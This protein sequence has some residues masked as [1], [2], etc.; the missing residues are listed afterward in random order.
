M[1]ISKTFAVFIFLLLQP[2]I[3]SQQQQQQQQNVIEQQSPSA[4]AAEQT[5]PLS[6]LHNTLNQFLYQLKQTGEK[7]V[8]QTPQI[9]SPLLFNAA[10][11]AAAMGQQQQR[12]SAGD[13]GAATAG[14]GGTPSAVRPFVPLGHVPLFPSS[15]LVPTAAHLPPTFRLPATV[16]EQH[17]AFPMEGSPSNPPVVIVSPMNNNQ[18]Q[19][20]K[21]HKIGSAE[22]TAGDSTTNGTTTDI[23][24]TTI[25]AAPPLSISETP[26]P[27]TVSNGPTTVSELENTVHDD[28]HATVAATDVNA[29]TR[30]QQQ[31]VVAAAVVP[32][33]AVPIEIETTNDTTPNVTVPVPFASPAQ[34][35]P[36]SVETTTVTEPTVVDDY[37][38]QRQRIFFVP[39]GVKSIESNGSRQALTAVDL[40]A[41]LR[42]ANVARILSTWN[43]GS[44]TSSGSTNANNNSNTTMTSSQDTKLFL[45]LV[46][47][48]LEQEVA[49]RLAEQ[50]PNNNNNNNNGDSNHSEYGDNSTQ[51]MSPPQHNH[52]AAVNTAVQQVF[53]TAAEDEARQQ[54]VQAVVQHRQQQSDNNN[55]NND[56]LERDLEERLL[57]SQKLLKTANTRLFSLASNEAEAVALVPAAGVHRDRA[58]PATQQHH[59]QQQLLAATAHQ[60]QKGVINLR[61][62][63]GAP[64]Q[65]GGA[66]GA[67]VEAAVNKQR[68]VGHETDYKQR[69][70]AEFD[71]LLDRLKA[72]ESIADGAELGAKSGGA[73]VAPPD[74]TDL[75][76]IVPPR[77]PYPS[78][79]TSITN[80]W[81]QQQQQH[82]APSPPPLTTTAQHQLALTTPAPVTL[83][84]TAPATNSAIGTAQQQQQQQQ[85]QAGT[86]DA[87]QTSSSS[88]G[89]GGD[90]HAGGMMLNRQHQFWSRHGPKT[91]FERLVEDYRWRLMGQ[92]SQNGLNDLIKALRNSNIGFFDRH[93]SPSALKILR[94]VD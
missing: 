45:A 74:D 88:G 76:L 28:G 30:Q 72:E 29:N 38:S 67:T 85:Q 65:S 80:K 11:A 56:D 16:M 94:R 91:K 3:R 66:A 90:G 86:N 10:A 13:G 68:R 33:L 21:R 27:N 2:S 55:N 52:A 89:G 51:R 36:L 23:V 70:Q 14:G 35:P 59:H 79:P 17:K 69:E 87:G 77:P 22:A 53:S 58:V 92:D 64:G 42:S 31:V 57:D 39:G 26:E 63:G 78:D 8:A 32:P 24:S 60:Q 19:H 43:N 15:L 62:G 9:A 71:R 7:V 20:S 46:E 93:S 50:Q 5:L 48:V 49:R 75:L 83:A 44:S 18:L 73:K 37:G 25:V 12:H 54:L 4:T 1:P 6:E 81:Q 40:E 84:P 41:F 47:R 61:R 82:V 34:T